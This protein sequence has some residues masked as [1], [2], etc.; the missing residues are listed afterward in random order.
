MGH[1]TER[2][3]SRRKFLI[4]AAATLAVT[5]IDASPLKV[6]AQEESPV[7]IQEIIDQYPKIN[8]AITTVNSS[9][10]PHLI[11]G[12]GKFHNFDSSETLVRALPDR[13]DRKLLASDAVFKGIQEA[14]TRDQPVYLVIELPK[15][16]EVKDWETKISEKAT[17]FRGR[18]SAFIIGN[19]LNA[20]NCPWQKEMKFYLDLYLKAYQTVKEISPQS[21]VL[22]WQEAYWKDGTMLKTFLLSLKAAGGAVDK[23]AVNVYDQW[24][25][26]G[27]RIEDVYQP[28]L[29]E[30][31]FPVPII[32]SE[33]SKPENYRP[34]EREK[35]SFVV[36]LLATAA[37]LENRGLIERAAW[38]SGFAFQDNLQ[39]FALS[40][41]S[42]DGRFYPY[43]ALTAFVLC[44]HLLFGDQITLA[45]ND[46]LVKVDVF[47]QGLP[48]ASFIWNEG[49][50]AISLSIQ[51]RFC[52][53]VLTPTGVSL[54]FDQPIT[55]LPAAE[56]K[57]GAGDSIVL[58]YD[59]PRP[60]YL[61][62]E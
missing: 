26:I 51:D 6:L 47:D 16:E 55:L 57:L 23:L 48:K 45:K 2:T 4:S 25:K 62:R 34:T 54:S 17:F 5:E 53:Q 61:F 59:P 22:P 41:A 9:D 21:Q 58:L 42:K 56:P 15:P 60:P 7:S 13:Y 35:A 3:F 14:V 46:G 38:F 20:F 19:E 10:I 12:I 49:T 32:I 37:Y 28:L 36:Q 8:P 30:C 11:K 29:N 1:S 24:H 33:L 43:P 52:W 44:Q 27:P 18:S 40:T 31:D 39:G 50:R